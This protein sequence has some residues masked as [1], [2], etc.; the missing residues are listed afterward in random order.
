MHTK[1]SLHVFLINS[2]SIFSATLGSLTCVARADKALRMSTKESI[3]YLVK[4]IKA[5]E[6][7]VLE[8]LVYT[9]EFSGLSRA[10]LQELVRHR[11]ASYSIKSTRWTLQELKQ[12][13]KD[14]CCMDWDTELNQ[15][16]RQT[17]NLLVDAH[18]KD[19]FSRVW[20]L[21]QTTGIPNDVLKY[22]LPEAFLTKGVMTINLRS[23]RNFLQLRS[24]KKALKEMQEFAKKLVDA[25]PD[26]HRPLVEDCLPDEKE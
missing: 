25:M 6:G 2:P 17:G 20:H 11:I 8:H 16:L 9:F 13:A 24:S 23:L 12:L 15:Y 1:N 26:E 14:P 7:S 22:A 4:R 18:N 21:S 19:M 3:E 10:A 5:G